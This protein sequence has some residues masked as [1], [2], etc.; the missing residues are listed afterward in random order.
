MKYIKLQNIQG[1]SDMDVEVPLR[2]PS[3]FA[4]RVKCGIPVQTLELVKCSNFSPSLVS[5]LQSTV[6]SVI[7]HDPLTTGETR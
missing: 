5:A 6:E 2:L 3:C 7:L 4:N 1:D